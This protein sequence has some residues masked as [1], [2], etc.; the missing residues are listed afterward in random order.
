MASLGSITLNWFLVSRE[1]RAICHVI[2][3]LKY[4]ISFSVCQNIPIHTQNHHVRHQIVTADSLAF[5][6]TYGM[7]IVNQITIFIWNGRTSITIVHKPITVTSNASLGVANHRQLD[8]CVELP[9]PPNITKAPHYRWKPDSPHKGPL[10]RRAF[11]FHGDIIHWH[12]DGVDQVQ[13]PYLSGT[14]TLRLRQNG[15]YFP[16]DVFKCVFLKKKMNFG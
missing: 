5:I 9:V 15:R 4:S 13:F 7:I 1:T 16:D 12:R 6:V 10:T 2:I 3:W 14:N 8:P 11:P